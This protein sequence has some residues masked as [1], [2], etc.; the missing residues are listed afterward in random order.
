MIR[1]SNKRQ[2]DECR[3]TFYAAGRTG[4][5]SLAGDISIREFAGRQLQTLKEKSSSRLRSHSRWRRLNFLNAPTINRPNNE[6][7][8]RVVDLLFSVGNVRKM[9]EDNFLAFLSRWAFFVAPVKCPND[10]HVNQN[11]QKQNYKKK[12]NEPCDRRH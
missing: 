9:A 7:Q 10:E 12:G 4:M 5:E 11:T 2:I 3:L 6:S 8:M 1:D